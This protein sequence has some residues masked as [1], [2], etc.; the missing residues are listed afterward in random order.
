M[1]PYLNAAQVNDVD[2]ITI[3]IQPSQRAYLPA[4]H[5]LASI[6]AAILAGILCNYLFPDDPSTWQRLR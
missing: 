6:F 4:G 1:I 2:S 5:I 3:D